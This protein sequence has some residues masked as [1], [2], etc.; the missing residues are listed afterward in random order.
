MSLHRGSWLGYIM[1]NI[2]HG[3]DLLFLITVKGTQNTVHP[4]HLLSTLSMQVL[5][6]ADLFFVASVVYTN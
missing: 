3:N 1:G 2:F 6:Q 5:V 4:L